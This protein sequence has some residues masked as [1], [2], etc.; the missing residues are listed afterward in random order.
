M[1]GRHRYYY[2][3]EDEFQEGGETLVYGFRVLFVVD[4][5]SSGK[6][7]VVRPLKSG[8]QKEPKEPPSLSP[9]LRFEVWNWGFYISGF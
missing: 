3:F 6:P 9:R 4:V 7:L 5:G 1:Y 8:I 2:F